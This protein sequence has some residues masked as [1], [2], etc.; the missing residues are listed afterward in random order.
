MVQEHPA[1][2]RAQV[3]AAIEA[4]ET[5][6]GAARRF[7][8]PETTVRRWYAEE[9]P[10]VEIAAD[11]RQEIADLFVVAMKEALETFIHIARFVRSDEY[12]KV[13][14]ASGLTVLAGTLFDKGA[15]VSAALETDD[16]SGDE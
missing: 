14:D 4:G 9:R 6:L 15:R 12:L 2:L 1:E 13:Q 7:N 3:I 5:K 8:V 10:K 16:E 11:K